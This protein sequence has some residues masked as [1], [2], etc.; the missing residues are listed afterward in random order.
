MKKLNDRARKRLDERLA[1]ARPMK[2]ISPPPKG[3]IRAMRDGLGMSGA[4][5]GKR[6]GAS[7]QNIEQLEKSE[8]AGTIQLQTLGK[9]A[10]ALDATLVYALVPNTSLEDTVRRR[11]R[12][13]AMQAITRVA[14]TMR[15]EDQAT[16]DRDLEERVDQYIREELADRDLWSEA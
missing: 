8:V 6:I 3:W 1:V 4:Q 16:S 11:A 2:Q 13:I 10:R 5:L 7:P 14:Q 12:A 9:L 15:L